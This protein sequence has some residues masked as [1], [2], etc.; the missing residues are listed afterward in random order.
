MSKRKKTVLIF[1]INT[2]PKLF[3]SKIKKLNNLKIKVIKNEDKS[4][5]FKEAHNINALINCPRSYFDEKLFKKFKKLEWVHTAGAGVESFLIPSFVKS[6]IIFTNGKILQEIINAKC[7]VG[8]SSRG[9]G[10][11]KQISEDGTVAVEN[12]FELIC[13][14]FVSN[15]STHG[16]FMSPRNE[17]VLKEGIEKKQDTYRYNK[18]QNIM[19]D[20]I[21]EVGGYCECF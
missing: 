9:M 11:V 16:A 2:F 14:D 17:G 19:R 5:L 21:C 3:L 4:K 6:N 1:D 8:I 15:P 18:A 10:S 12:D 7:T 20:I 13:W